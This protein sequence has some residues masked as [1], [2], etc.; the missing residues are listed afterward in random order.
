MYNDYTEWRYGINTFNNHKFN[1]STAEED[2]KGKWRVPFISL[3][4]T[5]LFRLDFFVGE[6]VFSTTTMRNVFPHETTLRNG[7][8]FP[9]SSW[10]EHW[11]NTIS[12]SGSATRHFSSRPLKDRY[13]E[14]TYRHQYGRYG[15]VIRGIGINIRNRAATRFFKNAHTDF[16]W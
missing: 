15:R 13:T 2:E 6:L 11:K 5:R 1:F 14:C 4:A 9:V 3:I 8:C 10:T 7:N 12:V 16:T